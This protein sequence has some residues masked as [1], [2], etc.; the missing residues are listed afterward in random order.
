MELQQ[1]LHSALEENNSFQAKLASF[2]ESLEKEKGDAAAKLADLNSSIKD[3]E[4]TQVDL[5][6]TKENLTGQLATEN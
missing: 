3:F 6:Q 5:I 1:S 4:Q 2:Q